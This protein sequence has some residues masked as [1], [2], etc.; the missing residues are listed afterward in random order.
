MGVKDCVR[1]YDL[2]WQ[3]QKGTQKLWDMLTWKFALITEA[4]WTESKLLEDLPFFSFNK[5]LY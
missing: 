4:E 2:F 1:I 3:N 5:R